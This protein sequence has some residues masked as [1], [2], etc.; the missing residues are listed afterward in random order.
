MARLAINL[1][2]LDY[3]IQAQDED[4]QLDN[5]MAQRAHIDLARDADGYVRMK[6][7]L[8]VSELPM[9]SGIRQQILE[10]AYYLIF[11]VH[12]G[13]VKIIM[14]FVDHTSDLG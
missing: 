4:E 5:W 3:I 9:H 14:I 7:V 12:L 10:E 6:G 8:Y 2:V 13:S 11:T 1:I